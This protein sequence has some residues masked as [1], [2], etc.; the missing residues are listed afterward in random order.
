MRIAQ[1]SRYISEVNVNSTR[2][3]LLQHTEA[4]SV[5][6][7][8]QRGGLSIES[9]PLELDIDNRAFFDS[10]GLKS[11]SGFAHDIISKGREAVQKS[12]ARYTEEADIMAMPNNDDAISEIALRRTQNSMETML[13]FIPEAPVMHWSGGDVDIAYTPDKLNFAWDTGSANHTYIPYNVEFTVLK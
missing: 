6:I 5:E 1:I 8:R 2:A 3:Q 4:A 9:H 7:T 10:L 11:V 12:M 13:T